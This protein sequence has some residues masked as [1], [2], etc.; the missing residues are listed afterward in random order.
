MDFAWIKIIRFKIVFKNIF[1]NF[2]AYKFISR[3][4]MKNIIKEIFEENNGI[5]R[6]QTLLKGG[7]DNYQIK[8]L[9]DNNLIIK[10][11]HGV[12][13]WKAN[14][15]N[16]WIDLTHLVPYG[17]LCLFTACLHYELTTF[18]SSTYHIAIPKKAKIV[19][20]NYPPIQLYY[21]DTK[22][23]NLGII[24]TVIQDATV[25]MYDIEKT[26]CD[27]IRFRNKVGIDIAKEVLK[28]YLKRP[29]RNIEKLNQY[30][31][32]LNISTVLSNFLTIL[33]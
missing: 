10:L 4:K 20:P 30:A 3:R 16:E 9:L 6:K 14:D 26:V 1:Y 28:N 17:I 25:K 7:I 27:I 8:Q 22:A 5:V 32:Q 31:L 15:E 21:W 19:L 13:K 24:E 12:Y 33:L 23:F 2:T 18:V 29:D 11:K